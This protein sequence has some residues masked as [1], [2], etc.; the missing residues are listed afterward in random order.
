MSSCAATRRA[1]SAASREQQ[2]RSIS[3]WLSETAL[4]RIQTPRASCSPALISAAATD[5]STP[6]DIATRTRDR[7]PPAV[8]RL[9]SPLRRLRPPM[10]PP[11]RLLQ[12]YRPPELPPARALG[13]LPAFR[14]PHAVRPERARSDCP[15]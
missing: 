14:P 7:G 5:E 11:R 15:P 10:P 12:T 1:S 13:I 2:L 9:G 6:P 4:R 8:T 3:E